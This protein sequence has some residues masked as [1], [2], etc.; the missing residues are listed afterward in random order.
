M[1]KIILLFLVILLTWAA[2]AKYTQTCKVKYRKNYG[3][4]EYYQVDV[5]FLSGSELNKATRTYNYET[6]STYAVIFWGKDQASVIE[7][8]SYTGC[9]STVTKNCITNK[10]GNLE[11]ED[12]QGRTWEICTS[13]FCY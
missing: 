5:T 9:G 13:N 3:W 6:Y 4:S 10:I 11:G 2:E 7:V 12:Q 8:S 1:K